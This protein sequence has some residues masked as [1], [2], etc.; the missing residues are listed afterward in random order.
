[1]KFEAARIQFSGDVLAAVANEGLRGRGVGS[2]KRAKQAQGPVV[3]RPISDNPGLNCNQ[4]LFV[5]F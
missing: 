2:G 3:R 5:F 4:G 1:M